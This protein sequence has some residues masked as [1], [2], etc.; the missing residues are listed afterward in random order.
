MFE[1]VDIHGEDGIPENPG[2]TAE[3]RSYLQCRVNEFNISPTYRSIKGGLLA[4]R[5]I[6]FPASF[7]LFPCRLKKT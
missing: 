1:R 6:S 7:M 2:D 3:Y 5:S 4:P